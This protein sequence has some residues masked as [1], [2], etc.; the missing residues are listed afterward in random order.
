MFIATTIANKGETQ[1]T[2]FVSPYNDVIAKDTDTYF[3]E[4][5]Q[6]YDVTSVPL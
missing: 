1:L 6:G 3:I 4:S 2:T 5:R